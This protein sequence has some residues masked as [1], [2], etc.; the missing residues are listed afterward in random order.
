M[1]FSNACCLV[2][3]MYLGSMSYSQ[4]N[5][6]ISNV[7]RGTLVGLG[8]GAGETSG[9][10]VD[11]VYFDCSSCNV[12]GNVYLIS[13][14]ST[15]YDSLEFIPNSV[16]INGD[17]HLFSNETRVS[18]KFGPFSDGNIF[19]Y[20]FAVHCSLINFEC[21]GTDYIDFYIPPKDWRSGNL[22]YYLLIECLDDSQDLVGYS[23]VLNTGDDD[24]NLEV[25][26]SES[27]ATIP[28]N[29]SNDVG[30][31][32]V[33]S[34]MNK[35]ASIDDASLVSF[36]GNYLGRILGIDESSSAYFATGVRGHFQYANG[37]LEGLDDDTPD[38][39]MDS[40]DALA[41]VQTYM[42]SSNDFYFSCVHEQPATEFAYYSNP[43]LAG[44]LVY[45]PICD[46]FPVSVP[47]D[48][49]V[50]HGTQLQLNV[51]GGEA[52]EWYPST[53]LSCSDCP[54]P[55][56]T[57]DTSVFYTVKIWNNDS[58]FVSRSLKL[59]VFPEVVFDSIFVSPSECGQNS[60]RVIF[61][62]I[63]NGYSYSQVDGFTMNNIGN[64]QNLGTGFHTFYA[65]NAS[66]CQSEDTTIFV[67]EVNST[68]V[69][70]TANPLSGAS[71]LEVNF[72]NTSSNATVF[73]W[74]VNNESVGNNLESFSFEQEG[75]YLVQ[76]V[77]WQTNETCSDTAFAT[78]FVYDSLIIHLP[79]VFTPNNDDVNDFLTFKT[80]Q[81]VQLQY[82]ILNRWGNEVL[83]KSQTLIKNN[84]IVLWDGTIS[85]SELASDGVYFIQLKITNKKGELV[86]ITEFITLKR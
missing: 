4:Q 64:F 48:T 24:L 28:K 53:N 74:F 31:S 71:P 84:A 81:N 62:F 5:H 25:S 27:I 80:N 51:T 7:F 38:L 82:S 77:G 37:V 69:S 3:F 34:I 20:T 26:A 21:N 66:G 22:V 73:E 43:V 41:N 55:I 10:K 35:S 49:S 15:V 52:Y 56:F 50:C 60:G 57:A 33:G 12:L 67:S 18:P 75:S 79:N 9:T 58:C 85:G 19:Q 1:K 40:T 70:F 42:N 32:V 45:T 17:I 72:T 68:S 59:N 23:L 14:E 36:N 6:V 83:L 16:V 46:T 61:P 11:Q 78:I 39:I 29:T 13:I 8:W 54:N 63:E 44:I 76:L 47:S 65:Q 86:E 30:F 2:F